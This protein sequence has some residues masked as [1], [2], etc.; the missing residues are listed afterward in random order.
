MCTAV[1]IAIAATTCAFA[2]EVPYKFNVGFDAAM[3]GYAGDASST[4]YRR[5]GFAADALFRY[6]YDARW[7]FGGN[8]AVMTLS[9][10]TAD[11]DGVRPGG[12]EYTFNSTVFDLSARVDFNFF[13]Y[14]MG[15]TFKGLRR[16]TPY[17]TSGV[18][19]SVA[20]CQGNVAA[21][22]NIPLGIGFRYKPSEKVNLFLEFS[23]T[24][25]FNDHIDGP[26]LSDLNQIKSSFI[27]NNDWYSRIAFGVTFEFSKRCE[28]CHYVD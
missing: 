15:E 24:K 8:L 17:L 5:P 25:V 18:G 16:W 10:N 3:S 22:P 12:I 14:G 23:V 7:Y 20:S 26:D 1:I 4:L 19:V 21:G 27:K 11:L 2:Q 28:T 9:G 13:P 6:Q